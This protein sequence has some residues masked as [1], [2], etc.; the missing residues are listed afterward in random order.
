MAPRSPQ[1]RPQRR[2]QAILPN[3]P[4]DDPGEGS[5]LAQIVE[6]RREHNK[7]AARRKRERKKTRLEN[8]RARKEELS[9]TALTLEATLLAQKK[10]NDAMCDPLPTTTANSDPECELPGSPDLDALADELV[11]DVR[12]VCGQSHM[13]MSELELI[14]GQVAVLV[15]HAADNPQEDASN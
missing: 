10:W 13:I 12:A 9:Q 1:P 2:L 8:L 3:R 11:E 15:D 5:H 4:I 14:Q 7:L 6:R